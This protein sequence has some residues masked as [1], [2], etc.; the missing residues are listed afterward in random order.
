[1]TTYKDK[2][3]Q[4]IK[5]DL[6]ERFVNFGDKADLIKAKSKLSKEINYKKH[7]GF[8]SRL[9]SVHEYKVEGKKIFLKF[10]LKLKD[11]PE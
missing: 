2:A 10:N 8:L 4:K 5:C 3:V 11:N 9:K 7:F 6:A 1:M